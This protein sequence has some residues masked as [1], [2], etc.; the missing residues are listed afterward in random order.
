MGFRTTVIISA[1]SL[2]LGSTFTHWIVDHNTLW[3]SPVT[4]PALLT[5][6][7]YYSSYVSAPPVV[8]GVWI[9]TV[10]IAVGAL[11]WKTVKGWREGTGAFLFDSA[12]LFLFL[13]V[14]WIH[15]TD[16]NPNYKLIPQTLP[17]PLPSNYLA[18]KPVLV[19]ALRDL[20]ASHAVSAV[21]L[22]GVML[23]QVSLLALG[24]VGGWKSGLSLEKEGAKEGRGGRVELAVSRVSSRRGLSSSMLALGHY[25]LDQHLLPTCGEPSTSVGIQNPTVAKA[26]F[27]V[28]PLSALLSNPASATSSL[29]VSTTDSS[30]PS[31]FTLPVRPLLRSPPRLH[32]HARRIP[33]LRRLPSRPTDPPNQFRPERRRPSFASYSHFRGYLLSSRTGGVGSYQRC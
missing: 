19:K 24:L 17:D 20:A 3:R 16:I 15:L 2:L 21:A 14:A 11:A 23:M 29:P 9:A 25:S 8:F 30:S 6:L 18:Q 28:V 4:E 7:S 1:T 32:R 12:G 33:P 31:P 5:S 27:H 22:T 13:A 26:P 10:G